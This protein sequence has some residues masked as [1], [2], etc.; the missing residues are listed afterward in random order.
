M[1]S[2]GI[3]FD[4]AES[5]GPAERAES[6]L[7][8][9]HLR[10]ALVVLAALTPA[11][12][13]FGQ[14]PVSS[15]L[16]IVALPIALLGVMHGALDPW[17]GGLVMQQRFGHRRI[18]AFYAAYLLCMTAI[19]A[20]WVLAPLATLAGFLA[21]SVIHFG[22]QDA[23]AIGG[24]C[25]ALGIL[26]Y[27]AVPVLGPIV[28]HAGEVAVIFDWLTGLDAARLE[29]LLVWLVKPVVAIWLVGLG[30]LVSR[31]VIEGVR[32]TAF[33]AFA[34]AVLVAAMVLLP[35]LV[36][37]A[38]YFCLLHSFGH[39]FDMA[40]RGQGPWRHWTLAQW[41]ARLWPATLVTLMLGLVGWYALAG[42]DFGMLPAREA[43]AQVIFCGLAA[44]TV[45][46]V[47]L[48]ELFRRQPRSASGT[49]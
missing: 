14:I 4:A 49:G 36:A 38:A 22:E 12:G 2:H 24:R 6:S 8:S 26:V 30:M 28:G 42:L 5:A 3:R 20:C 9:T 21:L 11:A 40:A 43:L 33:R 19:I 47:L 32:D 17:V 45:P 44:L 48:H 29:P 18:L 13:L 15:Q 46:H 7:R 34:L 39:L 31:M 23:A 10:I 35:P 41:S 27:G 25:D 37:F 16:A 1:R